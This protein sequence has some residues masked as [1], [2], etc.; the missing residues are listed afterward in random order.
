[1]PVGAC[2]DRTWLESELTRVSSKSVI[3][4]LE[5]KP[6]F[7][8][9]VMAAFEAVLKKQMNFGE[10]YKLPFSW[11]TFEPNLLLKALMR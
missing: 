7:P 10:R 8:L 11:N 3:L 5:G 9:R 4:V 2:R 6:A 1:M